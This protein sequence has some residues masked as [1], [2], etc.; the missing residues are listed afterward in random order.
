VS[1]RTCAGNHHADHRLN[2]HGLAPLVERDERQRQEGVDL[3]G[4]PLAVA[5]LT[6]EPDA[7][8]HGRVRQAGQNLER[9]GPQPAHRA[10]R[11]G[12]GGAEL[13]QTCL[14]CELPHRVD[15]PQVRTAA[16]RVVPTVDD[17]LHP[18]AGAEQV[19]ERLAVGDTQVAGCGDRTALAE[20]VQQAADAG[21]HR[22]SS[23]GGTQ[24]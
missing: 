24:L 20:E 8:L 17:P 23:G 9:L 22:R 15:T 16:G 1:P 7:E 10:D 13:H 11:V 3:V 12:A 2:R 6:A 14:H 18:I 4:P 21:Q 5:R 19:D